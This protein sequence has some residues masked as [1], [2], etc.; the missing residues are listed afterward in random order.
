MRF[1][2]I[3]ITFIYF[4]PIYSLSSFIISS[5]S[6]N[7]VNWLKANLNYSQDEL[8][9]I[10]YGLSAIAM[11]TSKFIIMLILFNNIGKLAEY[12]FGTLI[13]LLLR[14]N[15]GGLHFST[16]TK[17]L[18]FSILLFY[19]GCVYLPGRYQIGKVEMFILL[20]ACMT[21]N[22]IIGPV[23]SKKRPVLTSYQIK[24]SK[25]TALKYIF[26][27]IIAVFFFS[28]KPLIKIG[29]WM[30]L[31]QTVQLVIAYFLRKESYNEKQT[32]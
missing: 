25:L 16:Y 5:G 22:Y 9:L 31:L 17:C 29:F 2:I 15:T 7:K 11:E 26:L 13:L 6:D 32:N 12:L 28:E 4:Y 18:I 27:Y 3:L 8:E 14:I 23:I 20:L 1:I 24:K 19:L 30:I 21:I 10:R